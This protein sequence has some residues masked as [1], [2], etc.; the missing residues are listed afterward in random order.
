MDGWM[1]GCAHLF[2]LRIYHSRST[3]SSPLP[4]PFV[5][6][7]YFHLGNVDIMICIVLL[8]IVCHHLFFRLVGWI[9]G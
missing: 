6:Y 9:S 1:D 3:Y 5:R 8:I 2:D 4:L 7:L